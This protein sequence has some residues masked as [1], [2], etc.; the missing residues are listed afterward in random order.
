MTSTSEPWALYIRPGGRYIVKRYDAERTGLWA[1]L[2][3][4]YDRD[5]AQ[6][7]ADILTR[8]DKENRQ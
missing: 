8:D 4:L 5:K 3:P 7:L 1:T 2:G 6:K